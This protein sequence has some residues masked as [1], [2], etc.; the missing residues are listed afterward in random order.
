MGSLLSRIALRYKMGFLVLVPLTAIVLLASVT[1]IELLEQRRAV[2]R[3][4]S[5][6]DLSTHLDEIAHQHAVERGLTAGFLGSDGT[7]GK[8]KVIAQRQ[9]ADAAERAFQEHI[10]QGLDGLVPDEFFVTIKKLFAQKST[11]RERVDALDPDNRAFAYYSQLNQEAL[12]LIS[13]LSKDVTGSWIADDFTHFISL[14]KSKERA[15]QSRGAMNG[16]FAR[17][18]ASVQAYSRINVYIAEFNTHLNSLRDIKN[19]DF[20]AAVNE[21]L[22]SPTMLQLLQHERNFLNQYE[23]LEAIKGPSPDQ[24]F[25]LATK[26]IKQI[27]SILIDLTAEMKTRGVNELNKA[28]QQFWFFVA[29]LVTLTVVVAWG[30]LLVS[31]DICKRI[32]NLQTSLR[33]SAENSDLTVQLNGAG[34]DEVAGIYTSVSNYIAWLKDM[35]GD[36]R[37][38]AHEVNS[39]TGVFESEARANR[40]VSI[41]QQQ[42]AENAMNAINE[43]KTNIDEV[44]SSCQT[45]V[46]LSRSM[47]G[48]SQDAHE[49]THKTS[50]TIHQLAQ[51][52]Q[53]SAEVSHALS[54]N[55]KSIGGILNTIRDIADQ[56]NLL[57]LNAAIE[58]ARAGEQGRGFAVVADEVRSLA[59]RTQV[60]TQEIQ[61]IIEALQSSASD[62]RA[63]MQQSHEHAE[64]CREN[65]TQT[66][67][68]VKLT[69]DSISQVDE[70][71]VQ[72][73]SATQEQSVGSGSI[74][75]SVGNI[76]DSSK[77]NLS[78]AET[79]ETSTEALVAK[80]L[81]LNRQ[82]E[83]FK[84]S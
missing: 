75:S 15:G 44:A 63:S 65:S 77:K 64:A 7:N 24:W 74:A 68:F 32:G 5:I 31:S 84:V 8:D 71:L 69:T 49:W 82:T 26:R 11:V 58:A 25:P 38:V 47:R 53:Q 42:Q 60:S 52:I 3:T 59:Q 45:V 46:E 41:E 55:S 28:T 48:S 27:K 13:R 73:S 9:K 29:A 37:A 35:I 12:D 80:M 51:S 40:R 22:E 39:H 34:K 17:G 19:A 20:K 61:A 67:E 16:V 78:S 70:L 10:A 76:A 2:A 33:E 81:Q 21:L 1:G 62:I 23:N 56:T 4:Q 83:K 18:S 36:L 57:A 54:E 72:I 30:A 43:M 14:L 50:E 79:I 6:I 66:A